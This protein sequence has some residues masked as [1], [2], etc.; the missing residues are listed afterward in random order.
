[1]A[2][3]L[4]AITA[5]ASGPVTAQDDTMEVVYGQSSMSE[6]AAVRTN[7]ITV[8]NDKIEFTVGVDTAG[9]YGM[10][11]GI[12]VDAGSYNDGTSNTGDMVATLGFVAD[13]FGSWVNYT[14]IEVT[15]NTDEK[16]VVTSSGHWQGHEDVEITT[17]YILEA[18]DRHIQFET[19]VENTGS[20]TQEMTTGYGVSMSGM[21]TYLPGYG[22]VTSGMYSLQDADQLPLNW[23]G[24]YNENKG[25]YA[26]YFEEMTNFTA[27]DTWVDPFKPITL[28]PG[29]SD[30]QKADFYLW[31]E[32]DMT[33]PLSKFYE[34]NDVA[35]GTVEGTV[36]TSSGEVVENPY[37]NI[38]TGDDKL[39]TIKGD[40]NGEFSVNLAEGDYTIDAGLES[41][42][43]NDKVDV[44]VS[45]G[46]TAT[47]DYQEVEDPGTL[48]LSTKTVGE[49]KPAHVN[50]YSD[51]MYRDT[52][53]TDYDG[54]AELELPP[55]EY[56]LEL[57]YGDDYTSYGAPRSVTVE[58][59]TWTVAGANFYKPYEPNEKN[60]YGSDL[61]QHSNILDGTT[62]PKDLVKSYIASDLD[63]TTV[64][65]HN[66]V[67]NHEKINELSEEHDIPFSPGAEITTEKW[68]HFNAYNLDM[69]Q[70]TQWKGEPSSVFA[71]ARDNGAEFIQVN[72]PNDGGSYF[73]RTLE[74]NDD[75]TLDL[76]EEFVGEF[77]AI[78][79]N[80][81]WDEGDAKALKQTYEFWNRGKEYTTMVN[82]DCHSIW[83]EWGGTGAQRTYAYVEGEFTADKYI[84][85]L[86]D[87]NAFWT[88]GPLVYMEA[89]GKIPGET[90]SSDSVEITAELK[91]T[92]GLMNA[93][94][95][96]NGE[97]VKTF[98]LSGK[99]DSISYSEDVDG[100]GWYALQVYDSNE[101]RA[102]TN[103]IWYE[104]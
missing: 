62:P 83:Q 2:T 35:T 34:I 28:E 38:E 37:V 14:D 104:G 17:K 12:I 63:L 41:Y 46:S 65:D 64:T 82:S 18:G 78:E 74:T 52:I 66:K 23:A 29:E 81:A 98:D 70:E 15:T 73:D 1:M 56:N 16:I 68:G 90:V 92:D 61:H 60:Y 20:E 9:A 42:S 103:P 39:A 26:F 88:Y 3:M 19:T 85:A 33:K 95:I 21:Q 5:T 4:L 27:S 11:P 50:I 43:Q 30:H 53:Y 49:E 76:S 97:V 55:G 96:K 59:N 10:P 86:D 13:N 101:N 100:E 57:S 25:T 77:D 6:A 48:Y 40:E 75:G 94:L 99:T 93:E 31:E 36:K 7:D 54:E 67:T 89:D 58:S 24:G 47:V 72:H 44:S 8:R 102:H 87:Q 91:S 84:E 51:G 80:G 22:D 45:E 32:K 71:S 69:G 79:I